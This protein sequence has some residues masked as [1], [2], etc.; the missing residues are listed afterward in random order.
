MNYSVL[1]HFQWIR[2]DANILETKPRNQI[3]S[4]QF[5]SYSPK[6]QSHCLNGKK[7][8]F[9]YVWTGPKIVISTLS[10]PLNKR[11]MILAVSCYMLM[12]CSYHITCCTATDNIQPG[13]VTVQ[14]P[15]PL[16]SSPGDALVLIICPLK[17]LPDCYSA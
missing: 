8:L 14:L 3:K 10:S 13:Q 9:W 16:H 17:W 5:Y 15:L 6:S 1:S 11:A 2:L 12:C 7:R 4:N